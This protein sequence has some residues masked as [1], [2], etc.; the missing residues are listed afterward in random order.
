MPI[1]GGGETK[2]GEEEEPRQMKSDPF[3]AQGRGRV[4]TDVDGDWGHRKPSVGGQGSNDVKAH[5]IYP[6]KH[7]VVG[8]GEMA[9]VMSAIRAEMEER[10]SQLGLD[11][12]VL[13]AERLRQR[14][15]N[16]LLLLDAVGTCKVNFPIFRT[17]Q[18]CSDLRTVQYKEGPC[19]SRPQCYPFFE[20]KETT[21]QV[22][23]C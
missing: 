2:E 19:R 9:K 13:E 3:H 17:G 10:C 11:G 15:E 21:S 7:H 6:A 4:G 12:K 20:Y 16:D 8:H 23:K 14:T 5:V 1:V 22:E 18:H